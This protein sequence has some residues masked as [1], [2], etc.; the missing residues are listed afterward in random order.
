MGKSYEHLSVEE[1]A[2]LQSE[3]ARGASFDKIAV[4][5]GRDKSTLS[6]EWRRGLL[7]TSSGSYRV[8]EAQAG[9]RQRRCRSRRRGKLEAGTPLHRQVLDHLC[10]RRWSPQQIAERLRRLHPDDPSHWVSHE[11]IYAAIYAHPRGALKQGLIEALRQAKPRR[12]RVR[13]SAAAPGF[14]PEALRIVHRPEA[15]AE[16][17]V[18]GH[19]EGD[20]IKGAYNRSAVG[21]L[22]ERKTRFVVLCRMDG[23]TAADALAGFT[24]Q[25]KKL[26]AFLRESLTYDRGSELACHA[27]LA[28]RLK[29]DIW[30]ADPHAP[31]QRGSNENSNGLLR[32]FL[33]KGMD[34]SGVSQ[35]QLNDIA[36]LLN[37][38]PRKTLG[39]KT[40]EEVMSAEIAQ[41]S[42][43][44]ALDS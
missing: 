44:V 23:C 13:R 40:P 4:L 10:H 9:Y 14:L 3:R 29:L 32:Q 30:F 2:V 22:V 24:R 25:M 5:L 11:T 38:R 1:R 18:P 7:A 35:T 31:W 21:T 34:L 28:K 20:L 41:F 19:W 8:T 17:Q 6:R 42:K 26:P 16:R 12:G 15:V 33:P 36:R 37:G 43:N 27:E 39:W